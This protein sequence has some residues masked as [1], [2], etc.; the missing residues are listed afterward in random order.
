MASRILPPLPNPDRF[1]GPGWAARTGAVMSFGQ[2]ASGLAIASR[3]QAQNLW[4]RLAPAMINPR[5]VDDLPAVPDSRLVKLAEEAALEQSPELL[6]H[7]YRSAMFARAL[8]FIDRRQVDPELL[9]VCGLLH[10]VGMMKD[11][12]GEDF[13][14]RSGARARQCACD[15]HEP[16]EVG[17]HLNDALVVHTTVGV[18]P[19]KDGVLGAYTQYGAMVDLTGLRLTH[20]PKDFVAAVLR[21]HPRGAFKAEILRR[22]QKEA[23][24]VP[25]GR[26]AFATRVGFGLSVKLAPFPS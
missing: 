1:G 6:A 26:F 22:L 8:A 7:S 20:L 5:P 25:G 18:T 10:D 12:A 9:H 15:A 13:T 11:I 24:L 14:L 23:K 16:A 21:D 3:Q 2:C 4:H 17:E 19:D